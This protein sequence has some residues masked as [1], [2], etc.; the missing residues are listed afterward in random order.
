M[1]SSGS[2]LMSSTGGSDDIMN[3]SWLQQQ[4]DV[5]ERPVDGGTSQYTMPALNH[6]PLDTENRSKTAVG[7][8]TDE[9]HGCRGDDKSGA[10]GKSTGT[11]ENTYDPSTGSST[12]IDESSCNTAADVG[13]FSEATSKVIGKEGVE[14]VKEADEEIPVS[15]TTGNDSEQNRQK[16][17]VNDENDDRA[18][19]GPVSTSES[20][21]EPHRLTDDADLANLRQDSNEI[22]GAL[23]VVID[24]TRTKSDDVDSCRLSQSPQ[25]TIETDADGNNVNQ[26]DADDAK[27]AEITGERETVAN[28]RVKT[29]SQT[30]VRK[31]VV[32][33]QTTAPEQRSQSHGE[34]TSSKKETGSS[35]SKSTVQVATKGKLDKT[36]SSR[37]T[38]NPRSKLDTEQPSN[39]NMNEK[40]KRENDKSDAV[41]ATSNKAE[42]SVPGQPSVT[43]T[44]SSRYSSSTKKASDRTATT[45]STSS[46]SVEHRGVVERLS[47]RTKK[48]TK[49]A[50]A[51]ET[52][53]T[54]D[55]I[56][57]K[58]SKSTAASKTKTRDE[59]QNADDPLENA[60]D[61][62]KETPKL[63]DSSP[64]ST[65]QRRLA[66]GSVRSASKGTSSSTKKSLAPKNNPGP[67]DKDGTAARLG[68]NRTTIRKRQTKSTAV[69][70]AVSDG[71][72][73]TGRSTAKD[74]STAG[75]PRSVA[76][77]ATTSGDRVAAE[78][79][80]S[81]RPQQ[82]RSVSGPA[83]GDKSATS[84][85]ACRTASRATKTKQRAE[86]SSHTSTGDSKAATSSGKN[87][88]SS[89]YH[90]V[91]RA[92]LAWAAFEKF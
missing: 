58:K 53:K 91:F 18:V 74:L 61:E 56:A 57:N 32:E 37:L 64:E 44:K 80:D 4:T 90:G 35:S 78:S 43:A 82:Q 77:R 75:N 2:M 27:H 79:K 46:T 67:E 1:M 31:K 40:S 41:D 86:K 45:S 39:K 22:Q 81:S 55:S 16:P 47:N 17:H 48:P 14:C 88:S 29:R 49:E 66:G 33:G 59:P 42:V 19:E 71:S 10:Y 7:N 70:P 3:E 5:D 72:A 89:T 25:T 36:V 68:E 9:Q 83:L 6:C 76:D 51:N 30:R 28:P 63:I 50:A 15:D 54:P 85:S 8:T 26:K 21:A 69:N 73:A 12:S 92:A 84:A 20:A 87:H 23:T 38:A 62:V 34:E 65:S 52:Q 13:S 11:G 60:G 24:N